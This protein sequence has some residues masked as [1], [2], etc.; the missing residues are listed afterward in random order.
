MLFVAGLANSALLLPS[1]HAQHVHGLQD[2]LLTQICTMGAPKGA[3]RLQCYPRDLEDWLGVGP[4]CLL[5]T[6]CLSAI[7]RPVSHALGALSQQA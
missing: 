7:I 6:V 2:Q 1:A 5:R 4:Q 3:V